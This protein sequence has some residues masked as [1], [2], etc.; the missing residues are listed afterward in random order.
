LL[1]NQEQLNQLK[2]GT[3]VAFPR[4]LSPLRAALEQEQGMSK[5]ANASKNKK[6]TYLNLV[7][8]H[9]QLQLSA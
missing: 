8:W 3:T 1:T 7:K 5:D 9:K 2:N 6:K 4:L